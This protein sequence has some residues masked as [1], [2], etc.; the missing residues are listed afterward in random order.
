MASLIVL[1]ALALALALR[2]W[3]LLPGGALATPLLASASLLPLLWAWPAL[4]AMPLPLHWS[5][6]PLVVLMLGWPLAILL[7]VLAG[8]STLL[9]VGASW[10]EAVSLTL[11]AGVLPASGMVVFGHVIRVAFGAQP[12]AYLLGRAF[13]VP[14]AALLMAAAVGGGHGLHPVALLLL[15][16][17]EASWTCAVASL[18]VAC[19]PQWL[20]TWSDA[21]Y[22]ARV[23]PGK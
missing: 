5:A 16:L 19:W 1:A 14:L 23:A 17:A 21:L 11:W 7:L 20:A 8:L 13:F 10:S 18:L 15:A 3:R 9:T 2:P 6:A 4:L 22:L 12:L